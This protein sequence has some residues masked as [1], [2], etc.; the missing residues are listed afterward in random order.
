MEIPPPSVRTESTISNA[1]PTS[2]LDLEDT[3]EGTIDYRGTVARRSK[4]GR[5]RSAFFI[6]GVEVSERF[7]FYGINVDLINYLTG[8]LGQS[9]ATAAA[10][11]NAWSGAAMLSPLLGAFVADS[12]LGRYRTIVVASLLY[13]LGLGFLTLSAL[14][15]NPK[16]SDC[17]SAANEIACSPPLLQIIFFFSALYLIAIAQG[18]HKPCVQAFGADQF[19]GRDPEECK[20]RSSFFN[21][22]YFGMNIGIT[23]TN[24][25]TTYIQ[26]NLSWALGFGI[27]FLV[28]VF[29]L[30]IF[31]FGTVT[32]R[33][34][35]NVQETSPFVRIGRV[36]VKALRSC[37]ITSSTFPV[38]EESRS[39][40][41][42]QG[43]QQ[44][45]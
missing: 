11:V 24:V 29:G 30:A 44:F 25:V 28:M 41:H 9:T 27:P 13:I 38:E 35:M 19:D 21:W 36:F 10:N 37:R 33:F 32:Y 8:P 3:V 34:P 7:A 40:L 1:V 14:L 45:K 31:L 2:S 4:S 20:A 39:L 15:P 16:P 26:D 17:Q 18:G 42:Y 43:S 12:F 23:V 5:W 6:I 22:W